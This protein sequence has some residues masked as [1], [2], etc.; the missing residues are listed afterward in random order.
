MGNRNEQEWKY[1]TIVDRWGYACGSP[2]T[3][4]SPMIQNRYRSREFTRV[5]ED[6]P[7]WKEQ[8]KRGQ[9]ATTNLNVV[10]RTAGISRGYVELQQTT[11][12]YLIARHADMVSTQPPTNWG[13]TS[14]SF[15]VL[16]PK[17][18]NLAAIGIRQKIREEQQALSGMTF[19]GE[20]RES[21]KMLKKPAKALSDALNKYTTQQLAYYRML[22]G[23]ITSTSK[24]GRRKQVYSA[25]KAFAD[26][27]SG[28]WL[29]LNFG[30]RPLMSDIADAAKASLEFGVDE[31]RI[32]RVS[33]TTQLSVDAH[34]RGDVLGLPYR[35]S[36]NDVE[37][38]ESSV[39]WLVG[40]RVK[41]LPQ[42]GALRRIVAASGFNL[43]D[44]VP[45][46]WELLP[47]SFLIDYF[48]NIGDVL[49]AATVDLSDIAWAQKT[50]RN[51]SK[52]I[53]GSYGPGVYPG[54]SKV[55]GYKQYLTVCKTV[56]IVRGAASIPIPGLVFEFPAS[57]V[58]F[59]NLAA[60]A[61]GSF[62]FSKGR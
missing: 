27:L 35:L 17:T 39:R 28:S 12:P 1:D 18:E 38:W 9:S 7:R 29:E 31:D 48:T 57:P 50:V 42:M 14:E 5:G 25:R 22:N 45:T 47:W 49:S 20:F 8:V 16:Q 54:C 62:N 24:R 59:L 41:Q 3:T 33:Y 52:R 34:R 40:L 26:S 11:P 43:S 6:N 32:K 60:L 23:R 61:Y 58:K 4:N 53:V 21:L 46:A 10:V 44:V 55:V 56:S 36:Y 2:N 51:T 37:V 30:I 13:P 15:S 19:L